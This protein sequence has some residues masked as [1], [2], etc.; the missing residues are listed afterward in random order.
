[1]LLKRLEHDHIEKVLFHVT[2][3]IFELPCITKIIVDDASLEQAGF[4][5]DRRNKGISF[6]LLARASFVVEQCE[7]ISLYYGEFHIGEFDSGLLIS[8]LVSRHI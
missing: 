7:H 6:E 3:Q 5:L 4:A 2:V 1:V 8:D